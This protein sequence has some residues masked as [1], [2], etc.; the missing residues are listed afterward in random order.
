[1]ATDFLKDGKKIMVVGGGVAVLAIFVGYFMFGNTDKNAGP[2]SIDASN[3]QGGAAGKQHMDP[4][5]QKLLT[6]YNTDGADQ[7]QNKGGTFISTLA[8][9]NPTQVS[10]G[11]DRVA[12]QYQIQNQPQANP[13]QQQQISQQEQQQ[14]K[15]EDAFIKT[16][17]DSRRISKGMSLAS[18]FDSGNDKKGPFSDWISSTFAPADN[19]QGSNNAKGG[20]SEPKNTKGA[21]IIAAYATIPVVADTAMDSDDSNSPAF[22]HSPSGAYQGAIFYSDQ[23]RLAGDGI[24]VHISGMQLNGVQCKVNAYAL[25]G[26]TQRASIASTTNDRWGRRILLPAIANGIGRTGQLY[27]D[28]NSQMI[29]TD[30]GSAYRSSSTPN[31]KA[32][33]GTIVGGIG[34]QAGRVMAQDAARTPVKQALVD[35]NFAAI[36]RFIEPVYQSDCGDEAFSQSNSTN[37]NQNTAAQPQQISA[38]P[39]N[40]QD[41]PMPS[42]GG[43]ND[44]YGS[45]EPRSNTRGYYR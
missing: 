41:M 12:P 27:E 9:N 33:A 43:P 2:S 8:A 6:T 34:E 5:Y 38:V 7:A 29:I 13:Q 39:P 14:A 45:Y 42:N 28:S 3:L 26:D 35:H 4:Q 11:N 37:Q 19:G 40:T 36:V 1:M 15:L 22:F 30:G 16:V 17:Y 24:R 18:S 10:Y 31:G 44:V 25:Q 20:S 23:N 32:V 21:R